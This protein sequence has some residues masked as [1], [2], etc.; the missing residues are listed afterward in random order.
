MRIDSDGAVSRRCHSI[1]IN[2]HAVVNRWLRIFSGK[3]FVAGPVVEQ[4]SEK[5]GTTAGTILTGN[6]NYY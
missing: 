4:L 1:I 6:G 3:D 2:L 5:A